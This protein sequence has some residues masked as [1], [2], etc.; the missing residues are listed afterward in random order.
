MAT[1]ARAAAIP[2][3]ASSAAAVRSTVDS[4][5]ESFSL[6][7]KKARNR[8]A[9]LARERARRAQNLGYVGTFPSERSRARGV[10]DIPIVG[11]P[12]VGRR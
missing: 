4:S 1:G 11:V 2:A 10:E 5:T 9:G 12:R 8:L 7:A 3:A 6:A